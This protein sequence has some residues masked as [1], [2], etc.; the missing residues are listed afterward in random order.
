MLG[1]SHALPGEDFGCLGK[2]I[3][4]KLH[5]LVCLRVFR[6]VNKDDSL[7]VLKDDWP[8]HLILRISSNIPEL[9]C[10]HARKLPLHSKR[11]FFF[12]LEDPIGVREM[13]YLKA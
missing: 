1:E 7:G 6:V 9:Y 8:A 10:D 11:S 5:V 2:G 13:G 3:N 12:K 4:V